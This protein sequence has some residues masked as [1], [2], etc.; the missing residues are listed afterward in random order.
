[1]PRILDAAGSD[2]PPN[3]NAANCLTIGLI[4]NMP[5]QAAAATERQF[6]D[7]IRAATPDAVVLLKCSAIPELPR[8]E[9]VRQ[10]LAKRYRDIAELWDT[11]LDGLIVT[12][13]EPRAKSLRDEPYWDTLSRVVDWARVH[14]T[15]TIWSCLAAHAAV[16]HADGIERRRLKEKC[17]GVFDCQLAADHPMTY[18]VSSRSAYHIRATMTCRSGRSKPRDMKS[19]AGQRRQV[20]TFSPSRTAAS[21][22]SSRATSNTMP[23]RCCANIAA[24]RA[25]PR[26]RT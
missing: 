10:D 13:T 17:F 7:L 24:T 18:V 19:S 4:N 2:R 15:S 22:C 12:G 8:A 20:S 21:S 3:W 16:L 5:D 11:P 14:T 1:M 6:A 23:T 9:S 26:R 25:L